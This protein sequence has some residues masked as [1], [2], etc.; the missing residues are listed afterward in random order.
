MG[1]LL[2]NIK[3]LLG[4][5]NAHY[6][7]FG[8]IGVVLIALSVTMYD[9]CRSGYVDKQSEKRDERTE[10]RSERERQLEVENAKLRAQ[11]DQL[12][13]DGEAKD[14]EIAGLKGLIDKKGGQ[15]EVEQ[16][17]L[18]H[19]LQQIK[20]EQGTCGRLDNPDAQRRCVLSKLGIR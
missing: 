10:Q 14:T 20:S 17:R 18:E 15:I 8:V 12:F 13:K 16:K 9:S 2:A 5:V 19:E 4:R 6:L 3:S 7:I 11:A 1:N